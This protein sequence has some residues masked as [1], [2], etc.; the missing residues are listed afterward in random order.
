MRNSTLLN[1][2]SIVDQSILLEAVRKERKRK[3]NEA[4][5]LINIPATSDILTLEQSRFFHLILLCINEGFIRNNS[6]CACCQCFNLFRALEITQY[7]LIQY[8]DLLNEG[9][10]TTGKFSERVTSA[11][12]KKN[13]LTK[14]KMCRIESFSIRKF[15]EKSLKNVLDRTQVAISTDFSSKTAYI[16]TAVGYKKGMSHDVLQ[17]LIEGPNKRMR[18]Y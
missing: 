1:S 8:T 7:N 11:L 13:I 15:I 6:S 12:L 14:C 2:V 16:S 3:R 10:I 18:T 9:K 17:K 5:T 4:F